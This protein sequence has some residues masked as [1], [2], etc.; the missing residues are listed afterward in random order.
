MSGETMQSGGD[1]AEALLAQVREFAERTVAPRAAHWHRQGHF[2]S[3]TLREAAALGL[4]GLQVPQ[5]QGG[6]GLSFRAKARIAETLAEADF[7]FA[8][9]LINT[10]NV[11]WKLSRDAAPEVAAR[12]LPALLSGER[13]GATA[14][15]EP[16]AGTDFAAIETTA[17]KDGDGWRLSGEKAW[18]VN[19]AAADLIVTFAQTEPGSG[20]SGIAAFLVDATRPG[21]TRLPPPEITGPASIGTG[22]FRLDGYHVRKDEVMLSAGSAFRTILNDINGARTYVAAMCCGMVAA[23]LR[24][25][26]DYGTRRETFGRLLSQHQGWRWTLAEAEVD[27]AAARALVSEAAMRVEAGADCRHESAQA[28]IFATRVA[29]RHLPALGQLMGA[30]GLRDCHPFG[31][32]VEGA[33]I[34]G[35]VDGTTEILLENLARRHIPAEGATR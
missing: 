22:S 27:L 12:H 13:L 31:R 25:A 21:F 9:S 8:L 35:V 19:A 24:I 29:L 1:R 3:D 23:A 7:G 5:A 32:H 10:G 15:T 28:K 33:R 16:Q 34:A 2:C 18:I 14:L 17:T 26:S 11:A 20:A 6:A 4:T 30:E